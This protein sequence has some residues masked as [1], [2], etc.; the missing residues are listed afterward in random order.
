M[1]LQPILIK[2]RI[3][4]ELWHM[5]L[6]YEAG[7][8]SSKWSIAWIGED[9]GTTQQSEYTECLSP[10]RS[11]SLWILVNSPMKRA[12]PC[13]GWAT[14]RLVHCVRFFCINA[15]LVYTPLDETYYRC[16][17]MLV[18]SPCKPLLRIYHTTVPTRLWI[19]SVWLCI[20]TRAWH[21]SSSCQWSQSH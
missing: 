1:S 4:T 10:F 2:Y 16:L 20:V 5:K 17:G 19:W 3:F 8:A 18:C 13:H 7:L 12:R 21:L 15:M 14:F 11:C 9:L 6:I